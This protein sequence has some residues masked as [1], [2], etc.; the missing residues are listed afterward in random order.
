VPNNLKLP[1][2]Y[3]DDLV[4]IADSKD[5]CIAKLKAQKDTMEQKDL[6]R[7]HDNLDNGA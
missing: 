1:T 5:E 6:K 3:E 7:Q 4:V 2:V